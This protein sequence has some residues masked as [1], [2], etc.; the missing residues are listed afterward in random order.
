MTAVSQKKTQGFR[1]VLIATK[2]TKSIHDKVKA[3]SRSFYLKTHS[4]LQSFVLTYSMSARR[5]WSSF[6]CLAF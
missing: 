1:K 2:V 6:P 4:I 5:T 3:E